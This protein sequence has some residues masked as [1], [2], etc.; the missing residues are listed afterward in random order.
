[1]PIYTYQCIKCEEFFEEK[2]AMKESDGKNVVCPKCK[3]KGCKKIII[4]PYMATKGKGNGNPFSTGNT[5]CSGNCCGCG[6]CH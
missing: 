6:G 5:G 1:M 4:K 3:T 2:R